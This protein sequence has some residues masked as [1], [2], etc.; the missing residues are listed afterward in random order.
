MERAEQ[1]QQ[2]EERAR[3]GRDA[4]VPA[5]VASPG[6]GVDRRLGAAGIVRLQRLVGNRA[7]AAAVAR[8]PA[9]AAGGAAGPD[10]PAANEGADPRHVLNQSVIEGELA[11]VAAQPNVGVTRDPTGRNVLTPRQAPQ[12]PPLPPPR[13]PGAR[14]GAGRPAG[15]RTAGGHAAEEITRARS[16]AVGQ[17]P[18]E[19]ADRVRA[20]PTGG[21][22]SGTA[23]GPSGGTPAVATST[24]GQAGLAGPGLRGSQAH[25]SAPAG[26]TAKPP[27]AAAAVTLVPPGAA[28]ALRS[29]LPQ[30]LP[31]SQ[32]LVEDIDDRRPEADKDADARQQAAGLR[33]AATAHRA[34]VSAEAVGHRQAVAQHGTAQRGAVR[35]AQAART[36]ALARGS[37]TV[38][39]AL[40]AAANQEKES[41][42]ARVDADVA[43]AAAATGEKVTAARTGLQTRRQTLLTAAETERTGALSAADAETAR[44]VGEM[45]AAAAACE[46][47][48]QTQAARFAGAED[49]RPE[50]RAAALQVGRESAADIRA[51]KADVPGELR[52]QA[53]EHGNRCAQ[54]VRDIV[55]RLTESEQTLVTEIQQAGTEAQTAIRDGLA[56]AVAAVDGRLRQDV[57]AVETIATAA[58]TQLDTAAAQALAELDTGVAGA[59]R[60]LETATA[61]VG[62][63][64]QHGADEAATVIE[65]TPRPF[66]PGVREQVGAAE[67]GMRASVDGSR[68]H[69]TT[70]VSGS[71][72]GFAAQAAAFDAAA[73]A[74]VDSVAGQQARVRDGFTAAVGQ[75]RTT[76]TETAAAVLSGLAQRQQ[77]VTDAVLAEADTA[78]EQTRGTLAEMNGRMR[79][80]IRD[81]AD[82]S[83]EE[84]TRPRTDDVNTRAFE[85]A[86]QVDEGWLAGL[87]RAV[88]QIAIG[89][90][91]L[92]VVALV[93]A[94]I[95][96]AFGFVLTAWTAVMIAGAVLL[97]VGLI[98][99]L[100]VRFRQ[101]ELSG[102]PGTAILLAL[103]DTVGITGIVEGVSGRELVTDRPLSDAD[104]T[105]RGVLGVVTLVGVILGAR[106]AIK[107][108]PGGTFVR[109]V[110]LPPGLFG[111]MATGVTSVAAE[112][113]S[114]V[115]RSARS[116]RDWLFGKS[117]K[118]TGC[119][120]AGTPVLTPGGPVPIETLA[121]GD[122]VVAQDPETGL[123]SAEPVTAVMTRTVPTVLD[124]SAGG[125]GVT[126]SPEHPFR[127][128]ADGW[129]EAGALRAGH[130]LRT[131][132]GGAVAVQ[133][134]EPRPGSGWTVYNITVAGPHTYHVGP[135]GVLVHN[136][137]I[138]AD[139]VPRQRVLQGE[140]RTLAQRAAEALRRAEA[141]PD[142]APNRADAIR[143]ADGLAR[144]ARQIQNDANRASSLE[145]LAEIEDWHAGARARLAQLE[146]TL[147]PAEATPVPAEPTTRPFTPEAAMDALRGEGHWTTLNQDHPG[148]TWS[149]RFAERMASDTPTQTKQKMI[150]TGTVEGQ[151]PV[152]YEFSVVYDHTTGEFTYIG[153]SGGK[154]PTR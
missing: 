148:R 142:D 86:E 146:G 107:G 139:F 42:R 29:Q 27:A 11:E 57:A 67:A 6:P 35:A 19:I 92:V 59:Q 89:L 12:S 150:V 62:L 90:V 115:G 1:R 121:V 70:A 131:A 51:K 152:S 98:Y 116:V 18:A 73:A 22:R 154:P 113:A 153:R 105:E 37:A 7:V 56:G 79:T 53:V 72:A 61:A 2:G 133:A 141:L 119:F 45:E 129:V 5:A 65:E 47:A 109:P 82:R 106:A 88:V 143:Q 25:S 110:E 39:A 124:I 77:G 71:Q 31:P 108:P 99:N 41:L 63:D 95:A 15:A 13:L 60:E 120:V 26:A 49:P 80:G 17:L 84:A 118:P 122:L 43:A 127:V 9:G 103:S 132:D 21:A 38:T 74:L 112:I 117:E 102:Q 140:A 8:A 69:L 104:R 52:R 147:P 96:A 16:T 28:G 3:T 123:L 78:V 66:L 48:G 151:P 100:V 145:E 30:G 85:A 149:G 50:Q 137:A 114:G 134:V 87:G 58:R 44:A 33:T 135:A 136:K 93:V 128:G 36:A 64:L 81:A 144:E 54:H 94:A 75:V 111:R 97:A 130:A 32:D 20:R 83:V 101:Q 125:Q 91:V 24:G 23:G 40:T 34:V 55:G 46:Q 68:T 4:G 10:R 76:R 126:C 14:P 138:E